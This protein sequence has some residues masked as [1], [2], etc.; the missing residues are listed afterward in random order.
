MDVS[1][2]TDASL[3]FGRVELAEQL[4]S[5][6]PTTNVV[7]NE[8]LNF[9]KNITHYLYTIV[10][11]RLPSSR[12]KRT[13]QVVS[14]RLPHRTVSDSTSE[15]TASLGV[16][17]HK[18]LTGGADT[19]A[20]VEG[21][22]HGAVSTHIERN[23]RAGVR[24]HHQDI[25]V[26]LCGIGRSTPVAVLQSSTHERARKNRGTGTDVDEDFSSAHKASQRFAVTS[27]QGDCARSINNFHAGRRRVL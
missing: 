2:A 17:V 11:S 23:H 16:K 1:T 14:V 21:Q 10:G 18:A 9:S 6:T 8:R 24:T 25:D 12:Y 20:I 7:H 26:R 22:P 27:A 4:A 19:T 15:P 13:H 5:N 3:L